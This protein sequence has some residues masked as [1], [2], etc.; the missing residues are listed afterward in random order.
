MMH[1]WR[2]SVREDLYCKFNY[3]SY[4]YQPVVY[5]TTAV[6]YKCS[7]LPVLVGCM[8]CMVYM[9]YMVPVVHLVFMA[10]HASLADKRHRPNERE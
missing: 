10:A 3:R 6:C 4:S 7:G 2:W 9:V 1:L 5:L 8:V